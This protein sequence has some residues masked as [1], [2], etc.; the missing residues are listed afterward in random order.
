MAAAR[1]KRAHRVAAKA[2]LKAVADLHPEE[3]L[4]RLDPF[5]ATAT[6]TGRRALRAARI[7]LMQRSLEAP[8]RAGEAE[9]PPVAEAEPVAEVATE[10]PPPPPPPKPA[11]KGKLLSVS[12]EDAAKLLMVAPE[13]EPAPL[14]EAASEA[15]P[16]A[17]PPFTPLDWGAA[18]AGL[19]A[20]DLPEEA[21]VAV[22]DLP[23]MMVAPMPEPVLELMDMEAAE[24]ALGEVVDDSARFAPPDAEEKAAVAPAKRGKKASK[25]ALPDL[26]AQFAA[27]ESAG[28]GDGMGSGAMI[29]PAAAFAA[30]DAPDAAPEKPAAKVPVVDASAAF[31][32]MAE[33]EAPT[34]EKPKAAAMIDPAA[35]FA[36]M[37][38]LGAELGETAA[39]GGGTAGDGGKGPA[40]AAAK[41][42]PLAIDLS[43]QFAAM[44]GDGDGQ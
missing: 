11:P 6:G 32:A 35:A 2:L 25:A 19:A 33:V 13:P 38:E 24:A 26:S 4:E 20:F 21:E 16:V 17:E 28:A 37:A 10:P 14:P 39:K 3:A 40:T 8:P 34:P 9:L 30:M 22:A 7:Q 23:V 5:R 41:P 12:L 15:P 44:S 42:K 31:A 1:K 36:A 29:D 43:A 18:A 27:L